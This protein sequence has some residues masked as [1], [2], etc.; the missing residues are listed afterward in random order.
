MTEKMNQTYGVEAD[1]LEKF[2]K[3]NLNSNKLFEYTPTKKVRIRAAQA[4]SMVQDAMNRIAFGEIDEAMNILRRVMVI[5]DVETLVQGVR[6]GNYT[7]LKEY[8]AD[9]TLSKF[10][11][12]TSTEMDT[13]LG[14]LKSLVGTLDPVHSKHIQEYVGVFT[15]IFNEVNTIT[16]VKEAPLAG[17]WMK[18]IFVN[19]L[20]KL[21]KSGQ[22][23]QESLASHISKC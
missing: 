17:H 5:N 14:G 7:R 3:S 13:V 4:T 9:N 18:N 15:S 16:R 10:L 20:E 2:F 19:L 23:T 12:L 1:V 22:Y 11:N 6:N 21:G 8:I